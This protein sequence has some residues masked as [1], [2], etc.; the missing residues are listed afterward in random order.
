MNPIKTIPAGPSV[1]N[2]RF[3][4]HVPTNASSVLASATNESATFLNFPVARGYLAVPS[5]RLD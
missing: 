5:N 4:S 2:A 1:I 3:G